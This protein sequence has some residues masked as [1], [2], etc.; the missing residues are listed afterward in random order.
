M[1]RRPPRVTLF[2]YTTLFR[3]PGGGGG[4]GGRSGGV[5]MDLYNS[6]LHD[7]KLRDPRG[8]IITS[9]QPDFANA[10]EFMNALLKT[11]ITCLK[12]SAAFQ[13]AGKNYPAGS[14]VV[15]TAQ[16]FRP[17]VRSEEH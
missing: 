11:G 13:V 15:K 9:D 10:T 12:A 16:S 1:I 8:Y 6:V 5:S 14:Y 4:F 3:S 2:P 7:P 17:H